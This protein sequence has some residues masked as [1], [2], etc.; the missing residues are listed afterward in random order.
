MIAHLARLA[1]NANAL[2]MI[3]RLVTIWLGMMLSNGPSAVAADIY[4]D[5]AGSDDHAGNASAPV[6]SLSKAQSIAR[7]MAGQ[8]PVT[9]HVADGVYYLPDTLVFTPSDSGNAS[10][11]V[12]YQAEHESGVVL[13][14]G[15]RLDLQWRPYRDGIVMAKTAAGLQIDQLFVN[16]MNQR[17]AR[18]PNYD[19]QQ[20]TQ[21]YQGFAAD[22]F[23]KERAA[24]WANP[25]GGY[26]HAMHR[27]R[28]GGYHYQITGK[29]PDGQVTY[30]GGWQNNRRMGMHNEFRMVENIFEELDAPGEWFHD[31]SSDTLYYMPAEDVDL[32]TAEIEVVRL[33]HL[34]E[35]QGTEVTPVKFIT[36]KGFVFRHAA[37][38]FMETKEPMLRSDWAIYR[39]GAMVLSGTEDIQILDAEFDQ[40]GGNAIFVSNYNRRT[41]IKGCHIHDVG[42]SGVCWVGDPNAVRDPLFEYGQKND[43]SKIDRTPGPKTNRY[44]ADSV[45][46]DCLIHGIGRVERQPAG[47]QIEMAQ[48]IT[49]R[50]CS[51]YDC[52]R[53]GINIGDGAWGGH[54]IERCDVFDTV[55]ETHDHGSFNS[56]GRDRY[57]SSD[58]SASQK[59]I[60]QE[61]DLPFLDAVETTVIRNS[62]WRCD[63]GWDIDL[64]DGSSNYD[65]YNNLM[66]S[67]GLKLREGFRRRAWNNI[68]VNN[69]LHPHV[70]YNHSGDE[71]FSN[72]FMAAPRGARMPS[73]T[74]KGK[75][76]DSNLYY[77]NAPGM[78]D[79]YT[80]FGWDIHSIVADPKF[81]DPENGDF[82]VQPGSPA[83]DIGFQNF[84]M[85]Q[86]GVKKPSLKQI[87]RTPE[88]PAVEVR[89]T[90][91]KPRSDSG[92]VAPSLPL[93]W[94]GAAISNLNGAEFSAYGV[95][96]S[97]GGVALSQISQHSAA[98]I[99]GLVDGD[100]IQGINGSQIKR[101][102]DLLSVYQSAGNVPLRLNLVRN[103]QQME[104]LIEN[105]PH[106]VFESAQ[107]PDAFTVLV[108]TDTVPTDTVPTDTFQGTVDTKPSTQNASPDVL[109]DGKLTQ[110]YGPVFANGVT[111]GAYRLD[112]GESKPV[113]TITS[114]TANV[115][116]VRGPQK[117][118]LYGCNS[119]T[120]PGWDLQ[121][122]STFTPLTSIDTRDKSGDAFNAVALRSQTGYTLGTYRWI[123]WQVRP[124]TD[125]LENSAFQELQA[126]AAQGSKTQ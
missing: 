121:D 29:D 123:V 61:P 14:G 18:Y 59:V 40:V 10:C 64:D 2:A 73:E 63:H 100:L 35:F 30:V 41:L 69:G 17:M 82:R 6:A 62:R 93:Y 7:T 109:V 36:L 26:I 45:I 11:P 56:W 81:V 118:T 57:W 34:I 1:V 112:L 25:A 72:L 117:L 37:R 19:P 65:I 47:V 22:A 21:A 20:K 52:A 115:N 80:Q 111:S 38:T 125:K 92:P 68:T 50:D 13:S 104:L 120:D 55:L 119:A 28:W 70:W 46:E 33:R 98:A 31:S 95:S 99:A 116:G 67:G 126:E 42:A 122:R 12:T 102:V 15:S 54:L 89:R 48:H 114:W 86:F 97:D 113:S 84:P 79:R 90:M 106:L 53:A 71:V 94:L 110:A 4:V 60:D 101:V 23:A 5:P 96:Q 107:T 91:E 108:P 49:V 27:A 85:D 124:V 43:L 88:I 9:V 75:R 77:A 105:A 8:Q 83:F 39:G 3:V 58:R 76:V 87:A 74:A 32:Q 103:Q 78:A 24:G 16:G 51:V 66:L 44:P